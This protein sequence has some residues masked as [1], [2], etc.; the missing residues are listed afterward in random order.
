[1]SFLAEI[2]KRKVAQ[3]IAVYLIVAWLIAQ[4]VDIINEP[5]SLPSWFDTVV[6]LLLVI[7]FPIAVIFAWIFDI[8]P[9]G[10]TRTPA[11]DRPPQ[12]DSRK[13]EYAL[14]GL[15]VIGIAWLVVRDTISFDGGS[16]RAIGT[17]V[18]VLMDTFAPRGVYDQET[19]DN[20][21]TN[22]DVLNDI[23]RDLPIILQK[24]AIG[25][26][27][28]RE[29]QI[30]KQE[31]DLILIHRSG[32]FHS[33]NLELGFGYSNEPGSPGYTRWG[34]LYD[35]ADNKLMALLGFIGRANPNTVFLVYSR[36]TGG[37]WAGD[38]A[39]LPWVTNLEGRFPS[40]SGRVHTMLVP[41]GVGGGSFRSPEAGQLVR[42]QVQSLLGLEAE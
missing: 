18:V 20:S 36:G 40:L 5:L 35:I 12:G 27:W 2:K 17:P 31:P 13:M 25:P 28:D 15:M 7:G 38:G 39:P 21:G 8:T 1:M 41:G 33:M 14:L 34:R 32:F 24:E 10:V 3:I 19:R 6:L 42:K 30:L 23:L 29:D 22:A 37:G 26:V 9:E 16:D 11:G 4:V